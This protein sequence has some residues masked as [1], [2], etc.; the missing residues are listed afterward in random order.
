[1][2]VWT[3]TLDQKCS[4]EIGSPLTKS[5]GAVVSNGSS[6]IASRMPSGSLSS[7]LEDLG[8]AKRAALKNVHTAS[9]M[10]MGVW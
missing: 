10:A 8:K 1:M 2:F 5:S 3:Q 6:D 4:S 9:A 7:L